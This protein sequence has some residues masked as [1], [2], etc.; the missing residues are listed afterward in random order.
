MPVITLSASPGVFPE[1]QAGRR[2]TSPAREAGVNLSLEERGGGQKGRHREGGRQGVDRH[3]DR[4]LGFQQPHEGL[5][6]LRAPLQQQ[7]LGGSSAQGAA[8][9]V[10]AHRATE[11]GL[12]TVTALPTCSCAPEALFSRA[13]CPTAFSSLISGRKHRLEV[14]RASTEPAST[15]HCP[16]GRAHTETG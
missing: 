8:L 9:R 4:E 14:H 11:R 7:H 12:L 16:G 3:Q 2:Q 15:E 13:S 5:P 6:F 10:P 1:F